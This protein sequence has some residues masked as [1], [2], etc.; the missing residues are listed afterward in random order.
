MALL[1]PTHLGA[2]S[3]DLPDLVEARLPIPAARQDHN[4]VSHAP[5]GLVGGDLQSFPYTDLIRQHLAHGRI[6][7]AQKL[8]EFARDLIPADSKILKALAPPRI[9]KINR[10]DVDR[11]DEFHW[12]RSS[13]AKHRGQWVALVGDSL[14]ASAATLAT[15]LSDLKA[16]PPSSKPLIHHLD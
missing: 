12:L 10:R 15:L 6:L 5:A 4:P 16:N 2:F 3:D 7:D 11:S 14:F 1:E 8:L 13:G 9:S